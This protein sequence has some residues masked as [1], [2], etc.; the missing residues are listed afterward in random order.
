[1]A[2]D[3]RQINEAASGLS[4]HVLVPDLKEPVKTNVQREAALM[5]VL[6]KRF[7]K[8]PRNQTQDIT[9]EMIDVIDKIEGGYRY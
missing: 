6:I 9:I 3:L 5:Y 1:M 7:L 2:N 8:T 4:N